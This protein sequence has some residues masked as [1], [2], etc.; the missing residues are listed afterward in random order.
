[1]TQRIDDEHAEIAAASGGSP[2]APRRMWRGMLASIGA[3]VV[4]AVVIAATLGPTLALMGLWR[5]SDSLATEV[6]PPDVDLSTPATAGT[7]SARDLTAH[8]A[9][10]DWR[11]VAPGVS[12]R[13]RQEA[14]ADRLDRVRNESA[15][16]NCA[17]MTLDDVVV[18]GARPDGGFDV[19]DAP[20]LI[21][22]AVALDLLGPDFRFATEIKVAEPPDAGVIAGD[23]VVV[24]SGDPMLVSDDIFVAAT[25]GGVQPPAGLVDADAPVTRLAELVD[26][27]VE[28]QVVAIRGDVVGDGSY[29][30]DE[31]EIDSWEATERIEPHAGLLI[32]RG[33]LFGST[34]GLNPVQSAANEVLRQLRARDISVSGRSRA[35]PSADDIGGYE[36]IARVESAPLDELIPAM[37]LSRDATAF[38]M[39][40]K[41]IGVFSSGQGSTTAGLTAV[42]EQ[43]F[44]WNVNQDQVRLLD[45]SGR[46]PGATVTCSALFAATQQLLADLPYRESATPFVEEFVAADDRFIVVAGQ[47]ANGQVLHGVVIGAAEVSP[48]EELFISDPID[49]GAYEPLSAR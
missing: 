47:L 2:S 38:E 49:D 31:Y 46:S 43:L 7:T 30:D 42:A 17:L 32:N 19:G 10:L 44:S 15:S 6:A 48:L 16:A 28:Q 8:S 14:L 34:Y 21:T 36:T 12:E 33:L 9:V 3:L 35:L 20:M 39:L 29:F 4:G 11:R 23:L 22:A 40:L 25:L 45:G 37:L 26:Q 27:L 24:G 41:E 13:A 18:V 5:W 1:M